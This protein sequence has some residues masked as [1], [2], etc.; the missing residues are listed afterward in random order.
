MNNGIPRDGNH[1]CQLEY[2]G[3]S[4][5]KEECLAK[6]C[7]WYITKAE[8]LRKVEK[9]YRFFANKKEIGDVE[10]KVAMEQLYFNAKDGDKNKL[11]RKMEKEYG[12]HVQIPV[13]TPAP[14]ASEPQDPE[15]VGFM[16]RL[17][18]VRARKL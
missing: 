9:K 3:V 10:R 2:L 13:T 11:L 6:F 15:K 17:Q 14:V 5:C 1:V 4:E 8:G 7:D 16:W 18:S 12:K